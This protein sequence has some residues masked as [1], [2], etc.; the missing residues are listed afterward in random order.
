MK[1]ATGASALQIRSKAFSDGEQLM[2]L[3]RAFAHFDDDRSGSGA[4]SIVGPRPLRTRGER[5]RTSESSPTSS[6][7]EALVSLRTRNPSRRCIAVAS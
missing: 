3:K 5:A 4:R 1:F 2:L 7:R 6:N